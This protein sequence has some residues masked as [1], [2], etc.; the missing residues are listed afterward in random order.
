MLII[1]IQINTRSLE[2]RLNMG[3]HQLPLE[4]IMFEILT[5]TPGQILTSFQMRLQRMA[6]VLI[7]AK[8]CQDAPALCYRWWSKMS[9]PP[10]T[11]TCWQNI[12]NI[13][14]IWFSI[15]QLQRLNEY[16]PFYPIRNWYRGCINSSHFGWIDMC[17]HRAIY[18]PCW[19]YFLESF[20]GCLQKVV[21]IRCS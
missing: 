19:V 17:S 9:K 11:S 5:K 4:I 18:K 15:L 13:P 1:Y 12:R 8:I 21:Q 20:N 14:Y 10:E 6:A 2:K 16:H 7:N 3:D